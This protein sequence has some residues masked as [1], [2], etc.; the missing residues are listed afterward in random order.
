MYPKRKSPTESL[1]S[2]G[3]DGRMNRWRRIS[4]RSARP[5]RGTGGTNN[6]HEFRNPTCRQVDIW[7]RREQP[8]LIQ[9]NIPT[10][11]NKRG[12]KLKLRGN[13]ACLKLNL[14]VIAIPFWLMT[15]VRSSVDW[16]GFRHELCWN[17]VFFGGTIWIQLKYENLEFKF[18]FQT[19]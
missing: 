9:C 12:V 7:P 1:I 2:H 3:S 18:E 17:N 16:H 10:L 6:C 11:R 4:S 8:H 14:V 19:K 5:S 13:F 15:S